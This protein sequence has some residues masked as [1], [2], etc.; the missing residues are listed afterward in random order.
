M[1]AN[2]KVSFA[3]DFK[4]LLK[5]MYLMHTC[6]CLLCSRTCAKC[7]DISHGSKYERDLNKDVSASFFTVA[8]GR[9]R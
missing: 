1:C 6:E 2:S 8:I 5:L 7:L 4:D 3:T 9:M